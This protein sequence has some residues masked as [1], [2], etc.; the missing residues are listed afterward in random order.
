MAGKP[1]I[2]EKVNGASGTGIAAVIVVTFCMETRFRD[3]SLNGLTT[4]NQ[5]ILKVI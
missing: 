3:I 4:E 5:D 2:K 1:Y